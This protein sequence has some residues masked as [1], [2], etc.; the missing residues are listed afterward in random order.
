ME[1][2]PA[3]AA[4]LQFLF[5]SAD[6]AYFSSM[7]VFRFKKFGSSA[8]NLQKTAVESTSKY[9]FFVVTQN[10]RHEKTRPL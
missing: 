4:A 3:D 5:P 9:D 10:S 7:C 2:V 8:A 6:E 1:L